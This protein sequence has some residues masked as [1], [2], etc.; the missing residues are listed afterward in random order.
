VE[1]E[2]IMTWIDLNVPL[3]GDYTFRPERK[4]Y[5]PQDALKWDREDRSLPNISEK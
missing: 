2:A 4:E 3:W 5:R 1:N